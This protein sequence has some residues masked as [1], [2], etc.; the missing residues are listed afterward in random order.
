MRGGVVMIVVQEPMVMAILALTV[1]PANTRR[2]TDIV[3]AAR[4]Q[5]ELTSGLD[6]HTAPAAQQGNRRQL[7]PDPAPTVRPANTRRGAVTVRAPL[8]PP[9]STPEGRTRSLRRAFP[10]AR[11]ALL[12]T[13][14]PEAPRTVRCAA[15]GL[16]P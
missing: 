9:A 3:I 1:R 13:S 2:G 5:Q 16:K 12:A 15:L 8:V 10:T 11:T 14:R 6:T 4:V 7:A